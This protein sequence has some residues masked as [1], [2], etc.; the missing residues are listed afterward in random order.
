M[1]ER[2]ASTGPTV[3]PTSLLLIHSCNNINC[4]DVPLSQLARVQFFCL[5]IAVASAHIDPAT[6][7]FWLEK[8]LLLDS[9][10]IFL[11]DSTYFASP[12]LLTDPYSINAGGR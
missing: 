8:L 2:E 7:A 4:L 5:N 9:I 12:S 10:G 3:K 6:Q 1:F 11:P